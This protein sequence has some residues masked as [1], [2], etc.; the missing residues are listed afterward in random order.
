M[1]CLAKIMVSLSARHLIP[2]RPANRWYTQTGRD[3][4]WAILSRFRCTC[5]SNLGKRA[6]KGCQESP[7]SP[8]I[9]KAACFGRANTWNWHT[10]GQLGYTY[11]PG[12]WEVKLTWHLSLHLAL[13]ERLQLLLLHLHRDWVSHPCFIPLIIVL[14]LS[15]HTSMAD[16]ATIW[17]CCIYWL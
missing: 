7:I 1:L 17:W 8:R 2:V 6:G 14:L 3:W 11:W 9:R 4:C 12:G 13:T 10:C 5:V 15:I 16:L